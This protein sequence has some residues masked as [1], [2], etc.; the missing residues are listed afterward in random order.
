MIESKFFTVRLLKKQII[1]QNIWEL[2]FEKPAGF[3]FKA[4]Q[5][6]QF[7]ILNSDEVVLRSYSISSA[8]TANY[9]EFCIKY[10]PDGKASHFFDTLGIGHTATF[11]EPKGLFALPK[12]I[13][14]KKHFIAT[15]TG[16]APIMAMLEDNVLGESNLLFGVRTEE[17]LFWLERLNKLKEKKADFIYRLTLSRPS[18]NWT[19]LKGRVSDYLEFDL[20]AH[21]F[22]CGNVEMVKDVRGWLLG[23]GLNTKNMHFEIF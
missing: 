13:E 6:V 19:G 10:L 22:I 1:A 4:G 14:V 20:G 3:V 11:S 16:F 18:E 21:Y 15:G 23:K 8:P 7:R 5:F 12:E 17:D 9:L 2:Q